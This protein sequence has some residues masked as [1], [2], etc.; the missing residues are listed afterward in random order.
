LNAFYYSERFKKQLE[1]S[2]KDLEE[3][4]KKLKKLQ[5]NLEQFKELSRPE[6]FFRDTL[7]EKDLEIPILGEDQKY[8]KDVA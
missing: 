2:K 3:T 4:K 7:T 6:D 8:K 1:Q 5:E